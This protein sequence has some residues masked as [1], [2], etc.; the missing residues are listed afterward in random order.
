MKNIGI[1]VAF[2]LLLLMSGWW[3]NSQEV[4]TA[5]KVENTDEKPAVRQ[6]KRK[7]SYLGRIRAARELME[8]D[9][10]SEASV[11][12]SQAIKEKP[13]FIEP[14][15]IL[16]EIY[17]R[18]KQDQKLLNLIEELSNKFPNNPEVL[19]LQ[20]R[21]W[22]NEQRFGET[23]ELLSSLDGL[24]AR[25]RLYQAILLSLQNNHTG[26]Q[27]VLKE[28]E[29][30]EV[31]RKDFVL[32]SDGIVESETGETEDFLRADEAGKVRDLMIAYEEFD[33]LAEGKS[34][35]LFAELA[36]ALAQNNEA[37]LAREFADVAIKEDVSYIDAWILRGYSNF[38][39]Q[40]FE[41]ALKDLRYAYELDPIRPEV[42][43]FLALALF[44]NKSYDEA[45]LFFEK[46]LEYDFQFSE[47][48]RW[49]LIDIFAR[50]KK[51]DRVL[52]LYKELLNYDTE[53][54][55]FTTAVHTAIDLLQS[56]EVA[57]EFTEILMAKDPEDTFNIN[58]HAWALIANEQS[59]Q[60]KTLL[61]Q[62]LEINEKNPRTHLNL[63]L[64]A[65][66]EEAW[67]TAQD[68]YQKAYEYGQQQEGFTSIVN[69]AVSKYNGILDQIAD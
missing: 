32:T 24:P 65:E 45:A 64:I 2:V 33:E 37:F 39:I 43:Y 15:L 9:Y 30:V 38:L 46:A 49:K 44:E 6:V 10:F 59:K 52:E 48:V 50:Q 20:T 36:Q 60:A 69:L 51:Y 61:K 13:D 21:H 40:N 62:A 4:N 14:Y 16:G 58:I 25:L 1:I 34:A 17:L 47:E 26:A 23:L 18:S 42:H 12:L 53:P 3:F 7:T 27:E 55:K 41:D 19:A 31:K 63:G 54:E 29:R 66:A 11:E 67:K 35:H 8:H 68:H 57:L 22:I 56:P 5:S 28:L